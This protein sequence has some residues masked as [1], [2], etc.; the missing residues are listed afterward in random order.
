MSDRHHHHGHHDHSD[1]DW[2]AWGD[3]LEWEG[4]IRLP[5]FQES[6]AW[7]STLV[8]DVGRAL[9][10]GSG[11][12]YAACHFAQVFPRAEVVAVDGTQALLDRAV[13]RATSLNVGITTIEAELPEGFDKLGIADLIWSSQAVHHLGDQQGALDQLAGCLHPGGLLAIAERGLPLRYLP[14]DIGIGRPGLQARLEVAEEQAF[15]GMRTD[16][17]GHVEVVEDWPGMLA[18]ADLVPAGT[19]TFLT[20]LPA[21]LDQH[22]RELLYRRLTRVREAAADA[23]AKDD[24]ETLDVLLDRD[25]PSGLLARPDAFYLTAITVQTGRKP[26]A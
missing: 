10:V 23:L 8:G 21:P 22:P 18:K 16:L 9:D 19:R 17:P 7:L 25:S 14:R 6:A 13:R 12:G 11:P 1:Y 15:D 5:A 24:L 3:Q 4:E 2:E 26:A 20:D